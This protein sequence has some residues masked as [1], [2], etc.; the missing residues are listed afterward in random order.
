[1]NDLNNST[2]SSGRKKGFLNIL[3]RGES[4]VDAREMRRQLVHFLGVVTIPAASLI[5]VPVVAGILI[6]LAVG[7]AVFS[8]FADRVGFGTVRFKKNNPFVSR[9]NPPVSRIYMMLN[10]VEREEELRGTPYF[11]AITFFMGGGLAYLFLPFGI[12]SVAVTVLA[13][14]DS[15]S[16]LIG[17]ALGGLHLPFHKEKTWAGLL[18]GLVSSALASLI[19]CAALSLPLTWAPVAA[20]VGAVAEGY[21]R[22][23]DDNMLIIVSVSLVLL[24]LSLV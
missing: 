11:S 18:G 21:A 10:K 3:D 7:L 4:I 2:L 5:G 22:H 12:A 9:L 17:S 6:F 20:I 8:Y 15:L 19:V 23:F 14:G 1:M 24:I 13:V 16:T